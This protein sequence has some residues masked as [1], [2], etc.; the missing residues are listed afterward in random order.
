[1]TPDFVTG[2]HP[3]VTYRHGVSDGSGT[4]QITLHRARMQISRGAARSLNLFN[5]LDRKQL[6]VKSPKSQ[7]RLSPKLDASIEA[8]LAFSRKRMNEAWPNFGEILVSILR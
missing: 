7:F 1:M 5:V 6:T 8:V 2:F 4:L 3:A